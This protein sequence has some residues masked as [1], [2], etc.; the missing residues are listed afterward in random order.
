MKGSRQ[1]AADMACAGKARGRSPELIRPKRIVGGT[2]EVKVQT[3][4]RAI[5]NSS[6]QPRMKP[7]A[8]EPP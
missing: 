8:L 5:Q 7:G 2:T 3:S 6:E 4:S 1:S